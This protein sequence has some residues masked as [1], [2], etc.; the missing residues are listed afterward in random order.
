MRLWWLVLCSLGC[1]PVKV[2]EHPSEPPK[3]TGEPVVEDT[4]DPPSDTGDPP[5]DT[6]D[7][8]P[9]ITCEAPALELAGEWRGSDL[10][11]E[12]IHSP[13]PV[14]GSCGWGMAAVDLNEDGEVDLL[15]VGVHS[16]TFALLNAGGELTP[17]TD[18]LFDG[19]E[20]PTGNGVAAGD[21]NQDGRPDIVLVRS[22]GYADRVY[23]NQGGGVF[24]STELPESTSESQGATLFDADADGDLDLFISRH[25]D[26]M[27]TDV[28]AM[29]A[30]LDRAAVNG[31]YLNEGGTFV[32]GPPVGVSDAATFQAVPMDVDGDGDLDLFL[33]N[34]FGAFIEPSAMMLNDG[35]G[36]FTEVEDCGCDQAMFGMGATASD[37]NNDGLVDLYVSDFGSPQLLLGLGMGLFYDSTLASGAGVVP[38]EDRVT[39]WGTTFVDLDQDGSDEIATTFGPVMMGVPGDWSDVIDD[40][41]VAGLDDSEYQRD[42]LWLNQEGLFEEAAEGLGFDFSTN[43]RAVVTADFDGDGLPDLATSGLDDDRTQVV[44]MH[45]AKGG[46]G[47]GVTVNFTDMGAEDIGATVEW[48]VAGVERVRWYLPTTTFSTSGPTLHLGLGGHESADWVRITPL[49]GVPRETRDV[50]AGSTVF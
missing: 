35:S 4:A 15:P 47:P 6:G 13:P 26:L 23:I 38:S 10:H 8:P 16:P 27:E 42:A 37:A 30:G 20:L 2:A 31:F 40:P 28:V 19:S 45:R 33:V 17:S 25:V 32:E 21:I 5:S 49:N 1:E 43:S 22:T 7:P 29:E 18:V 14:L 46:C 44:R 48:S 50:L 11:P 24:L 39:S 34:D 36:S 12:P 9:V 3:E 41:S